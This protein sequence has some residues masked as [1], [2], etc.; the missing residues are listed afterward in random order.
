LGDIDE[1]QEV[2]CLDCGAVLMRSTS[3]PLDSVNEGEG[4]GGTSEA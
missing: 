4:I 2:V 1:N 3:V